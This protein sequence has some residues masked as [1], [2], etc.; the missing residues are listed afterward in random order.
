MSIV[1][2]DADGSSVEDGAEL[3]VG[4]C[5]AIDVP[6]RENKCKFVIVS[7]NGFHLFFCFNLSGLSAPVFILFFQRYEI[8][9]VQPVSE[10]TIC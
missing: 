1:S 3:F 4:G 7:L 2:D 10:L 5:Y 8:E 6:L 9:A